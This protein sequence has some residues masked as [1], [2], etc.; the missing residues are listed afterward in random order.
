MALNRVKPL[1]PGAPEPTDSHAARPPPRSSVR[2][3][4]DCDGDRAFTPDGSVVG[5]DNAS[6]RAERVGTR[7]MPGDGRVYHIAYT[8][9]DGQGG[10]CS[11]TALVGVSHE[12]KDTPID[13]GALFD[14]TL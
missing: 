9:D 14:S 3:R 13:G 5:T 2:D 10:T 6:V 8:A 4:H 1:I 11:G 12:V 7:G